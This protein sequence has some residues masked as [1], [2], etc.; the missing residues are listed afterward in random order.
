[1]NIRE[2]RVTD[3]EEIQK[4]HERHYSSEF[5]LPD[6]ITNFLCAFTVEHN[7]KVILAGG[8]KLIPELILV[9]DKDASARQRY[10][11]FY[12]TL[13]VSTYITSRSGYDQLHAFIQDP[14]W[15]D[16][17]TNHF[18]YNKCKGTAIY[19]GV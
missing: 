6:F 11:A 10:E 9:T 16:V 18:G 2:I 3:L 17:A 5:S 13:D 12:K 19:L 1:M 14:N 15:L 8:V 4:I 7:D